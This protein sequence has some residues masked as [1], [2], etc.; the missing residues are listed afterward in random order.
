MIG[1]MII[2]DLNNQGV[3]VDIIII[4]KGTQLKENMHVQGWRE[5]Q[6]CPL[7]G[8]REGGMN[9]IFCKESSRR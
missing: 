7:S 4:H 6:E 2:E 3:L 1:G 9:H 8:N 5:S